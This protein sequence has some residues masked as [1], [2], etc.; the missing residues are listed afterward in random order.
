MSKK[1]FEIT[2]PEGKPATCGACRWYVQSRVWGFVGECHGLP[3]TQAVVI[4]FVPRHTGPM[5]NESRPACSLYE[6]R[7]A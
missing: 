3:P 2:L 6:R 1:A 7:Q 4:D 5:V